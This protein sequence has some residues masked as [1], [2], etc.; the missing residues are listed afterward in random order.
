MTTTTTASS[1]AAM[2]TH[3][4]V[5]TGLV[6]AFWWDTITPSSMPGWRATETHVNPP[7]PSSFDTCTIAGSDWGEFDDDL[8]AGCEDDEPM[9]SC[10]ATERECAGSDDDDDD[11]GYEPDFDDELAV[12]GPYNG[13]FWA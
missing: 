1:P 8:F 12:W 6:L 4:D 13:H 3:T 9:C 2:T 10:G 11:D 5:A 7:L